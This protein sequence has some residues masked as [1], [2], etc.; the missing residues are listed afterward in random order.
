MA[1]TGSPYGKRSAASVSAVAGVR[2]VAPTFGKVRHLTYSNKCEGRLAV[3]SDAER[4][5]AHMLTLDPRVR[6][7]R[8]QPFTVDLLDRRILSAPEEIADARKRHRIRTGNKFYTPDFAIDWYGFTRSALE[9]K[10]EDFEGDLEYQ[11]KLAHG[12]C[13]LQDHGY[14]IFTVVIPRDSRHP[15]HSSL[16]LLKQATSRKDLWP[17]AALVQRISDVCEYQSTTVTSLCRQLELSPNLIPA[18]LVSGCVSANLLKQ[19][20][21]GAMSLRAAHGDLSHLQLLESLSV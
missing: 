15:I 10:L 4:L 3:E 19:H 5:T 16:A 17:D 11:E 8:T 18:M 7:F 12:M 6:S 21:M 20:I 13:I 9:V 2:N 14:R 1:T